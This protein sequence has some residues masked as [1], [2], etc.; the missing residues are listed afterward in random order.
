MVGG[1]MRQAGVLAAAGLVSLR[2]GVERLRDDHRR[3]RRLAE[4]LAQLPGIVIDLETVQSNIVRFDVGGAGHTTGSFAAA[5]APRG[6]R[7]SG[8]AASSGVRM[9]VHRHIDDDSIDEALEVVRQVT[10]TH[11]TGPARAPTAS[12]YG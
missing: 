12:L 6:V 5:L 8:G 4:G 2:S 11:K 10:Q 7:V 3:A 9:V 1:G